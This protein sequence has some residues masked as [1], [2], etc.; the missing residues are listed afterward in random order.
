MNKE[1]ATITSSV[2]H[3]LESRQHIVQSFEAKAK[4]ER[5][6][7]EKSADILT[8]ALGSMAFLFLNIVWFVVWISANKGVIPGIVVFDPYPFGLLT[9]IVSL[10]AIVLAII[11][12]ISQNRASR[13]A[14]LREEVAFYI[15]A[16]AEEEITKLMELQLM[17]LK[18]NHVHL[19]GDMTLQK[20]LQPTNTEKIKRTFEKQ[21]G[22]G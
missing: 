13:T 17:L 19:H 12:L 22:E 21:V 1:Y 20:M 2:K 9:M 5:T 3:R 14:I 11:V 18:K 6:I 16:L 10:E 15:S 7:F 8:H 4:N